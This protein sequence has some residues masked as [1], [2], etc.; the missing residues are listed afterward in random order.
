MEQQP[1]GLRIHIGVIVILSHDHEQSETPAPW[2]IW[3]RDISNH[4]LAHAL[5]EFADVSMIKMALPGVC[6]KLAN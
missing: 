1:C 4:I 2:Y 3:R 5:Y 6:N